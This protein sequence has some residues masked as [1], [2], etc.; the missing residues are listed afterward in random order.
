MIFDNAIWECSK[1]GYSLA[2][3]ESQ[4][5]FDLLTKFIEKKFNG[6]LSTVE[7]LSGHGNF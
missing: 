3:I 6:K 7:G 2:S 1:I 4:L 5:E